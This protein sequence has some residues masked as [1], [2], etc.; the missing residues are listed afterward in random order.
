[1]RY[2]YVFIVLLAGV[3]GTFAQ[4]KQYAIKD[5]YLY[6]NELGINVTN[7]IGNLL[8]L[9]PNTDDSPYGVTFRR[10]FGKYS[11]R[12]AFNFSVK[13]TRTQDFF[14]NNF[15]ERKLNIFNAD[16][17]AGLEWH[18]VLSKRMMFSYGFDVLANYGKEQ[19]EIL[20]FNFNG[21]TFINKINNIG[22]GTGP[23][24]RL[25][26]KLSD[27]IFFS[28]ECSLYGFYSNSTQSLI[29]NGVE[30]DE[31]DKSTTNVDLK[32]PQTLFLN[33]AF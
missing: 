23:M 7:V 9:N 21:T 11:F 8:S 17:R 13:N 18:L 29:T 30:T 24:V 14:Q 1:M 5:F 26:F 12:S 28:S 2:I 4:E 6:K 25:E 10:H 3:S 15:I 32:L 22:V 16:L 27:R 19:S 20:D 31:P 33:I